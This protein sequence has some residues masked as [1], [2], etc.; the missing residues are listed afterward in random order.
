MASV[1]QMD[2]QAMMAEEAVQWLIDE[3]HVDLTEKGLEL[4]APTLFRPRIVPSVP[5]FYGFDTG[6]NSGIDW[7]S[8]KAE[9][10][11]RVSNAAQKRAQRARGR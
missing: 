2:E 9:G 7:T 4:V 1:E 5:G 10:G 8:R 6:L 3:N 11:R